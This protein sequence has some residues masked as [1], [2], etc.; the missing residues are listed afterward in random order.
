MKS[1][2]LWQCVWLFFH[3]WPGHCIKTKYKRKNK[4]KKQNK[5]KKTTNDNRKPT[6]VD[7]LWVDFFVLFVNLLLARWPLQTVAHFLTCMKRCICQDQF[8]FKWPVVAIFLFF[9]SM[10]E[11]SGTPFRWDLFRFCVDDSL[12]KI[13]SVLICVTLTSFEGYNTEL[14]MKVIL[15]VSFGHGNILCLSH[16]WSH[17]KHTFCRHAN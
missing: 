7:R 9:N 2:I 3:F 13:L 17:A 1:R 6:V 16:V 11:C 12:W 10:L 5:N 4:T 14:L 8:Q 15:R